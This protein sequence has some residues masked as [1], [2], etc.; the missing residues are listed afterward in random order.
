MTGS[1]F[2]KIF[3]LQF[4]YFVKSYCTKISLEKSFLIDELISNL[5][6]NNILKIIFNILV[7]FIMLS[8][9][10]KLAPIKQTQIS[11]QLLFWLSGILCVFDV[12]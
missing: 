12:D 1:K 5:T 2:K 6:A 10:G 7:H 8:F 11:E 3:K 9:N 4:S